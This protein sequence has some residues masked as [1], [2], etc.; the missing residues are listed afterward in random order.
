LATRDG[1]SRGMTHGE[2]KRES[3]VGQTSSLAAAPPSEHLQVRIAA[4]RIDLDPSGPTVSVVIPTLNEARNLPWLASRMPAGVSEIIL[5]DGHSTDDTIAVAQD[6]WPDVRIVNQTRRGKG[7]ALACGFAAATCEIIVMIDADGSM[8]PG[9]I[10]YFVAALVRNA[11]YAK[12]SRFAPGGGSSDITRFRAAGNHVLNALT[13][14]I[15]RTSFTDLC[16]GFNAFWRHILPVLGLEVGEGTARRWGDGFEVE[17][18]INIRVHS[19]G[20]NVTEVPSFE[21]VRLHGSSNLRA[22]TDGWRVL[23]IIARESR[24]LRIASPG[25][26][27]AQLLEDTIVTAARG[28]APDEHDRPLLTLPHKPAKTPSNAGGHLANT[29]D[30]LER[31]AAE[32]EQAT[33]LADLPEPGDRDREPARPITGSKRRSKADRRPLARG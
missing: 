27:P 14:L 8:D 24:A 10:P 9:E 21:G 29:D 25:S 2:R 20:L 19:A 32:L 31:L 17:T 5:V 33:G 22:F 4:P 7:N 15:H 30:P 6:L 18:L 28:G 3:E 11:D 26:V 23:S 12:G 13:G 16:Y 1:T